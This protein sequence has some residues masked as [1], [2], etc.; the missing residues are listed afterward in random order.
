MNIRAIHATQGYHRHLGGRWKS[1]FARNELDVGVLRRALEGKERSG[2]G[3]AA[4]ST[5]P[6]RRQLVEAYN[7]NAL[8]LLR[9]SG[10]VE[11]YHLLQA[12]LELS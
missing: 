10:F 8:P 6:L 2:A 11:A 5:W 7:S 1:K 12:A 3:S 9:G 4:T